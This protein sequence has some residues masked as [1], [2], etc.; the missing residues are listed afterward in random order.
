MTSISNKNFLVDTNIL[1]YSL[2][3]KSPHFPGVVK[4]FQWAQDNH[5]NLAVAHQNILELI[6]TL[7][8]DYG[9][10]H[11]LALQK[12]KAFIAAPPFQTISPLPATLSK[13]F[14]LVTKKNKNEFDL[15]LAATA[16]DNQVNQI[17][18]HNPK[19][20]AQIKDLKAYKLNQISKLFSRFKN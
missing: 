19:D 1:V 3:R 16:L 10:S 18:T 2:D 11:K 15:Y 20:F 12:A 13:Y 17:I 14:T 8:I 9:L 4:F 6:H 5:I 7:Q